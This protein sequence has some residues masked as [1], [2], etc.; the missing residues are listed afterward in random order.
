MRFENGSFPLEYTV[1]GSPEF[2]LNAYQ[3][4][5]I[6]LVLSH[7]VSI[8]DFGAHKAI[9]EVLC[10]KQAS[11]A[12]TI[13]YIPQLL[14]GVINCLCPW[15]LLLAQHSPYVACQTN[16]QINGTWSQSKGI[17]NSSMRMD[18]LR[19]MSEYVLWHIGSNGTNMPTINNAIAPT[20]TWANMHSGSR[21]VQDPFIK[22]MIQHYFSIFIKGLGNG[23]KCLEFIWGYNLPNR[24]EWTLGNRNCFVTSLWVD[25]HNVHNIH[26][27]SRGSPCVLQ[28]RCYVLAPC[29]YYW[30]FLRWIYFI[31]DH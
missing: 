9:S 26:E 30:P 24:K 15:Y 16:P 31:K 5:P 3:C 10:Q 27:H 13:N 11:K 17:C 18:A 19:G 7:G 2:P 12:G 6:I 8:G 25:T 14:W 29:S 28:W 21:V 22:E 4:F 23:L 1:S 20:F